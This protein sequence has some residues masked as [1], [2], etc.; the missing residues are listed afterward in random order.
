MQYK[1]YKKIHYNTNSMYFQI[2]NFK[3]G[4]HTEFTTFFKIHGVDFPHT[5]LEKVFTEALAFFSEFHPCSIFGAII[6]IEIQ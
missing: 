3:L 2:L 6:A 5:F 1:K 4:K